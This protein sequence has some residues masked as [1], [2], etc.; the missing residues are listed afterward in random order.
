MKDDKTGHADPRTKPA[1]ASSRWF[2]SSDSEKAKALADNLESQFH[3][4]PVPPLQRDNVE[5]VR[6][7][8]QSFAFAPASRPLLTS[9]TEVCKAIAELK[10][11]RLQ[12]LTASRIGP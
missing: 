10:V 1:L 9:P 7:A 6:E 12:V 3:P 2:A 4:V 11:A 5:Q 8:M